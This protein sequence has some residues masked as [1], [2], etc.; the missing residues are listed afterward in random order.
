[1]INELLQGDQMVSALVD[2]GDQPF[3]EGVAPFHTTTSLKGLSELTLVNLTV[4]IEVKLLKG[5]GKV[6]TGQ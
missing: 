4:S 6:V 2:T 5:P 1:V 3:P